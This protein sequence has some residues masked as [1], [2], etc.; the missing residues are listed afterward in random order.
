RLRF[1]GLFFLL[2]VLRRCHSHGAHAAL[3]QDPARNLFTQRRVFTQI[4]F[5]LLGAVAQANFAI[6]K[7][8]ALLLDELV[9]HA[10]NDEI[11]FP[12]N[13]AVIHQL[14]IRLTERWGYLVLHH[15]DLDFRADVF[16]AA[17]D[18]PS[19]FHVQAN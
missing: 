3:L 19:L 4:I 18:L 11:A 6:V 5:R 13:P 16:L 7:P 1:D 14:E 8:V 2:S 15:A 10:E 12:A 9:F 17:L